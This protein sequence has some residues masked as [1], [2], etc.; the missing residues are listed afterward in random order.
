[1][2]WIIM[3]CCNLHILFP[4]LCHYDITVL[5]HCKNRI[6][7][8]LQA[9]HPICY[10]IFKRKLWSPSTTL[11]N[12][13][14]R[15]PTSKQQCGDFQRYNCCQCEHSII[16]DLNI[17]VYCRSYLNNCLCPFSSFL[18]QLQKEWQRT[19][20]CSSPVCNFLLCYLSKMNHTSNPLYFYWLYDR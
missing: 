10:Q 11:E 9:I 14:L 13:A 16:Q 8:F 7:P 6:S 19:F 2:I 12:P 3:H 17:N 18:L 20:L 5:M 15:T 4:A 1:M